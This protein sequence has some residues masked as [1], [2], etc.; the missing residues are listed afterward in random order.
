MAG[1]WLTALGPQCVNRVL[2]PAGR[3][4]GPHH[5]TYHRLGHELHADL[6]GRHTDHVALHNI[7]DATPGYRRMGRDLAAAIITGMHRQILVSAS[8]LPDTDR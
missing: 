1:P 7:W 3:Q 5:L 6:I 8:G 2:T 4:G